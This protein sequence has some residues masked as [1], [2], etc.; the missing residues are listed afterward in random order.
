[1]QLKK[2]GLG[3]ANMLEDISSNFC[4]ALDAS[5]A[6]QKTL[7]A[8]QGGMKL[9]KRGLVDALNDV[10]SNYWPLIELSGPMEL[11]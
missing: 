4:P 11:A 6:P 2:L 7:D 8:L 1:M 10:L 5:R 9:K 3:L